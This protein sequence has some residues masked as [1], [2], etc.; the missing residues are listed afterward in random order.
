M[1]GGYYSPRGSSFVSEVGSSCFV[2]SSGVLVASTSDVPG[3]ISEAALELTEAAA[4]IY[5]RHNGT[6]SV[7][8]V[9]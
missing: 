7:L 6:I 5:K 4:W 8:R 9:D 2:V 1:W 3:S